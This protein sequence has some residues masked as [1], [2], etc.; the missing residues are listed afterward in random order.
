MA[1]KKITPKT[2]AKIYTLKKQE[3]KIITTTK[4]TKPVPKATPKK[5]QPNNTLINRIRE[6][7]HQPKPTWIDGKG[8]RD[9]EYDKYPYGS[10]TGRKRNGS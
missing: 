6:D 1:V 10:L 7:W 4:T 5:S 8:L 3:P 9:A 2:K